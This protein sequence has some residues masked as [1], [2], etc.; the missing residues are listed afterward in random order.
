MQGASPR[1]DLLLVLSTAPA[2][3]LVQLLLQATLLLHQ[4]LP[5]RLCELHQLRHLLRLEG[6]G[7]A[8]SVSNNRRV[9]RGGAQDYS[10]SGEGRGGV[11]G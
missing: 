4:H 3:H 8:G 11:R 2:P 6:G 5:L 1:D 9:C 7:G 10:K